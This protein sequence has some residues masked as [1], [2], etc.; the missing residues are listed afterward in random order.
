[1]S[2]KVDPAWIDVARSLGREDR[3]GEVQYLRGEVERL[4]AALAIQFGLHSGGDLAK[5]AQAEI[6]RLK[7]AAVRGPW[8][9]VRGGEPSAY[10]DYYA[11]LTVADYE[12]MRAALVLAEKALA[13]RGPG[14]P[15]DEIRRALQEGV[16]A[17]H[18]KILDEE[19]RRRDR[20]V[21]GAGQEE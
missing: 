12:R 20:V 5:A 7:A 19:V 4:K 18:R 17:G 21:G 8:H 16:D 13:L 3:E 15:L 2:E 10:G 9:Y 11:V 6:E 14:W 1:M